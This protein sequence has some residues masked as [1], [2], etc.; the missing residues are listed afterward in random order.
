MCFPPK[1]D[2]IDFM[3]FI[4]WTKAKSY[5][6]KVLKQKKMHEICVIAFFSVIFNFKFFKYYVQNT[7]LALY[8]PQ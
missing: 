7:L 1:F 5:N 3:M 6:P 8:L 2:V 4:L